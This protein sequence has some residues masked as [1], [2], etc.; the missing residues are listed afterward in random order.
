VAPSGAASEGTALMAKWGPYETD[1]LD[2][3]VPSTQAQRLSDE[4]ET[5]VFMCVECGGGTVPCQHILA[6]AE[7]G[8]AMLTPDQIRIR[9]EH[10]TGAH[11]DPS[12]QVRCLRDL[13]EEILPELVA[14]LRPRHRPE[15][16][17]SAEMLAEVREEERR[18]LYGDPE[19]KAPGLRGVID[20]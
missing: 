11:G 17:T 9:L 20:A 14:S 15:S 7:E 16:R 1:E 13:L 18:V 8:P 5:G 2:L 4:R 6:M 19:S 12:D 3:I 10:V